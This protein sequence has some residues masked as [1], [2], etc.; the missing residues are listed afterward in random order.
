MLSGE[1]EEEEDDAGGA[2]V[3]GVGEAVV[4]DDDD[5]LPSGRQLPLLPRILLLGPDISSL[6]MVMMAE[7]HSNLSICSLCPESVV[8]NSLCPNSVS[9]QPHWLSLVSILPTLAYCPHMLLEVVVGSL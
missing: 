4:G 6:L 1:G 9:L 2:V 5:L 7:K 8:N 3:G